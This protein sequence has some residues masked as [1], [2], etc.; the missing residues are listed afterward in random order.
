MEKKNIKE[1][2]FDLYSSYHQH[3]QLF[4]YWK[5]NKNLKTRD[6]ILERIKY[7]QENKINQRNEIE[8]LLWVLGEKN[9]N[10]ETEDDI[11][12]N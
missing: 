6:E 12:S 3:I 10:T 2:L 4:E 8:T 7:I 9:V 5:H 1:N 11:R